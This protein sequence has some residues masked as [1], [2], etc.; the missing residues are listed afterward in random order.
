MSFMK[1]MLAGFEAIQEAGAQPEQSAQTEELAIGGSTSAQIEFKADAGSLPLE[2]PPEGVQEALQGVSEAVGGTGASEAEKPAEAPLDYNALLFGSTSEFCPD[3]RQST[4]QFAMAMYKDGLWEKRETKLGTFIFHKQKMDMPYATLTCEPSFVLKMP[5]IPVGVLNATI[6]FFKLVMAKMKNSESMVQIFWN[7]ETKKYFI[8][9][10]E[11]KVSGASIRFEHN[12]DYQND[13]KFYWCL[14][15]HSHNTMGAFFSGGDDNDEKAS[16]LFGVIG[17]LNTTPSHKWRAGC[18]GK[19]FNLTTDDIFDKDHEDKYIIPLEALDQVKELTYTTSYSSSGNHVYQSGYQHF[20]K[21]RQPRGN[22]IVTDHTQGYPHKKK[23]SWAEFMASGG[24]KNNKKNAKANRGKV[25]IPQYEAHDEDVQQYNFG[26]FSGGMTPYGRQEGD[27]NITP[28]PD[29]NIELTFDHEQ[30][31]HDGYKALKQVIK[32]LKE[33]IVDGP[34]I[35]T[36][37]GRPKDAKQF[38]NASEILFELLEITL[39]NLEKELDFDLNAEQYECYI[40]DICV[41]F[42]MILKKFEKV[43]KHLKYVADEARGVIDAQIQA[44]NTKVH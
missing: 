4:K 38:E 9:V 35:L 14:D 29:F 8:Y 25:Q 21:G 36:A 44:Q 3:I 30:V 43:E 39:F 10:P 7:E 16:R 41:Y 28:F 17:T 12:K 1:R 15:I 33:K 5:K 23:M 2:L 20:G 40:T 32:E 27:D 37:P 24:S 6:E 26:N 31:K 11:Q 42:G 22:V 19:Y 13:P 34:T 18:N